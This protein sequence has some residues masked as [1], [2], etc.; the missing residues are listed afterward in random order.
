MNTNQLISMGLFE[1]VLRQFEELVELRVRRPLNEDMEKV[2]ERYQ[3]KRR[4]L[5]KAFEEEVTGQFKKADPDWF[6]YTNERTRS[7]A[8]NAAT[9][10]AEYLNR[11]HG[12]RTFITRHEARGNGDVGYAVIRRDG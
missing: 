5:I 2:E 4:V 1:E 6:T 10:R 3:R 12:P 9:D 7:E 8:W 11:Q